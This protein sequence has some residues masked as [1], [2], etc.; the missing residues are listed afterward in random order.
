MILVTQIEQDHNKKTAESR[1]FRDV[2]M[3]KTQ[4][5]IRHFAGVVRY[6]S[7]GFV[8]KNK[9][10]LHDTLETLLMEST[11]INF[12]NIMEKNSNAKL[13]LEASAGARTEENNVFKTGKDTKISS[14]LATRFQIQ[15]NQLIEVL[16]NSDSHFV[17]CIKPNSRKNPNEIESSLVLR[18]LQYSGVLEAVQIRKNGYPIRRSL[19]EFRRSY[20]MLSGFSRI[21][22]ATDDD[23][24]KCMKIVEGLISKS[25]IY[26]GILVGRTIVFFRPEVLQ[27]LEQDRLAKGIRGVI[28]MQSKVRKFKAKDRVSDLMNA[29]TELRALIEAGSTKNKTNTDVLDGMKERVKYFHVSLRLAC[30]EM[31]MANRLIKR[32]EDVLDCKQHVTRLLSPNSSEHY[33]DVL[34]EYQSISNCIAKVRDLE[35]ELDAFG[36]LE[37]RRDLLKERGEALLLLRTAVESFDDGLIQ[38]SL[39][40]VAELNA[41][42]GS[43]CSEDED[44]ARSRLDQIHFEVNTL[45]S[46]LNIVTEFHVV[47]ERRQQELFA[48]PGAD[49]ETLIWNWLVDNIARSN[50]ALTKALL[51]FAA[52]PPLSRLGRVMHSVLMAI[53]HLRDDWVSKRWNIVATSVDAVLMQSNDAK[54]EIVSAT[55]SLSRLNEE[56]LSAIDTE[57]EFVRDELDTNVVLPTITAAVEN[58]RVCLDDRGKVIYESIDAEHIN[59]IVH[60]VHELQWAGEPVKKLTARVAVLAVARQAVIDERWSDGLMGCES[61]SQIQ[62]RK[63]RL[64]QFCD[65]I[66]ELYHQQKNADE[67]WV[68]ISEIKSMSDPFLEFSGADP[69]SHKYIGLFAVEYDRIDRELRL[70]HQFCVENYILLLFTVA[71]NV[72]SVICSSGIDIADS[73]VHVTVAGLSAALDEAGKLVDATTVSESAA[74]KAIFEQYELLKSLR[75]AVL[76]SDWSG[77]MITLTT[78]QYG[79]YFVANDFEDN[80]GDEHRWMQLYLKK[81]REEI[82]RIFIYAKNKEALGQ[83]R[84]SLLMGCV[85]GDIGNLQ[86][87]ACSVTELQRAV[88]QCDECSVGSVSGVLTEARNVQSICRIV[89]ELRTAFLEHGSVS[90]CLALCSQATG[91]LDQYG[92]LV[93]SATKE[94]LGL[95]QNYVL[96]CRSR[97]LLVDGLKLRP[98][99]AYVL[100]M[101]SSGPRKK[102]AAADIDVDSVIGNKS[103]LDD[104][105]MK[106]NEDVLNTEVLRNG[107]LLA[108]QLSQLVPSEFLPE[109]FVTLV[110]VARAIRSLREAVSDY[111]WAH[112]SRILD[113][114]RSQRWQEQ[115]PMIS[116]EIL[117]CEQ[118]VTSYLIMSECKSALASGSLSGPIGILDP[119]SISVDKVEKAIVTC[120]Q[121]HCKTSRAEA[122][123]KAVLC[124]RDLRKAQLS[125]DW[126]TIKMVLRQA[127]SD[128][129]GSGPTSICWGELQRAVVERDNYDA[130]S[131]IKRSLVSEEIE[132][133]DGII[134]AEKVVIDKLNNSLQQCAALSSSRK[135]DLTN[136]MIQLGETVAKFRRAVAMQQA[137]TVQSFVEPLRQD[138][139]V[140]TSAIESSEATL[141]KSKF[142]RDSLS[143]EMGPT[144]PRTLLHKQNIEQDTPH[145]GAVVL[146][147]FYADVFEALKREIA[148]VQHHFAAVELENSFTKA[149]Q[150]NGI[151]S[152]MIGRNDWSNIR[153][154]DLKSAINTKS[155]FDAAMKA[156]PA[157]TQN[158]FKVAHLIMEMRSAIISSVY[159]ALSPLIE[160]AVTLF[161][162]MPEVS[163]L[164]VEAVRYE[165]ENRWIISSM[166]DALKQ[167]RLEGTLG[168]VKLGSVS[169]EHLDTAIRDYVSMNPRTEEAKRLVQTAQTILPIR[170]LLCTTPVDWKAVKQQVFEILSPAVAITLHEIVLQELRLIQATADDYILCNLMES[171]LKKG[172]PS[173]EIG[174]L[175]VDKVSVS[176]LADACQA[177]IETSVRTEKTQRLWNACRHMKSLREALLRTANEDEQIVSEAYRTISSVLGEISAERRSSA[178]EIA[179]N[180]CRDEVTLIRRTSDL[181]D[182]RENIEEAIKKA[183]RV[184]ENRSKMSVA[185]GG[186]RSISAV[187][188]DI[189]LSTEDLD[190]AVKKAEQLEFSSDMLYRFINC[191]RTL[192][193]L[194]QA[195]ISE[196]WTRLNEIV[197]DVK[198]SQVLD[199]IPAAVNELGCVKQ[200]S[201][202]YQVIDIIE[203]ALQPRPKDETDYEHLYLVRAIETAQAAVVTSV[204]AKQLLECAKN[205]L[206]LRTGL[207]SQNSKQVGVSLRWFKLYSQQCPAGVQQEFQRAYI[208]HQNVRFAYCLLCCC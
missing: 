150:E 131:S 102:Q 111:N 92:S 191:A 73:I 46:A 164:E 65:I 140:L 145:K 158:L 56:L 101:N 186:R 127:E 106:L 60:Y 61:E 76:V 78:T 188:G 105:D 87:A 121:A 152:A 172:G 139:D 104:E 21:E 149:L 98:P 146:R 159:E 171:S 112:A 6:E 125:S 3:T 16:N 67:D 9:D 185:Q 90:K 173:G 174:Y 82:G 115:L 18:Q 32:L 8:E 197:S 110:S 41:K 119:S 204:I 183:S 77:I 203:K 43:F 48:R 142:A 71:V 12:K 205:V 178:N 70:I 22:L 200:E 161:K 166:T 47:Y 133:V 37:A 113:E 154:D 20:W 30:V 208:M 74:L 62:S 79:S 153:V 84:S 36:D 192:I 1:F 52:R 45:Q 49:L 134:E 94:E 95:L 51:P 83:M 86:L 107:L 132:A 64:R 68:G 39:L 151:T 103:I 80:V 179:W 38:E 117:G 168:N 181:H 201:H 57:I 29:R 184:Y 2:K 160:E 17:R 189:A 148:T 138:M 126:G 136:A 196:Q 120:Q 141:R 109:E 54:K 163:R 116:E 137:F 167:G 31:T 85:T 93:P 123:F 202:N 75:S 58:G 10:K 114:I 59:E 91:L 176:E 88:R 130:V 55:Q 206:L 124:I 96:L 5:E 187:V 50:E 13:Q 72:G 25:P 44:N 170:K 128:S 108:D 14:T 156:L 129:L 122:L 26:R 69:A 194:R 33:K 195:L 155:E 34:L 162:H 100:P 157:S 169:Y 66:D 182:I 11:D 175:V 27:A 40:K 63:K 199:V 118:P 19:S 81:L 7:V 53:F 177:A 207:S 97:E 23:H 28:F 89:I 147:D 143:Q 35:L 180:L 198:T 42:Y 165:L 144:S 15:L 135:G 193:S 190:A 24:L 4:F 99:V